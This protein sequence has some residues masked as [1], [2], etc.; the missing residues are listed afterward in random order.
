MR[1]AL[2]SADDKFERKWNFVGLAAPGAIQVSD[3]LASVSVYTLSPGRIGALVAVVLGLTGAVIGRLALSRSAAGV[4]TGNG[5]RGATM[6]LVLGAIGLFIGGLVVATA[7][8]G[9]GTGHGFGGG[10]VAMI[11]GLIGITFGWLAQA[12][13]RSSG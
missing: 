8:G 7:Q 13:S 9:L 12:R 11:V 5:R 2:Q 4:S 10:I 3:Q 1:W 6:A